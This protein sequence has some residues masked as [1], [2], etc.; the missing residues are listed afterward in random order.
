MT[1]FP[2]SPRLTKGA[3]IAV[4]PFN[5]AASIVVFQYNPEDLTRTITPSY[6]ESGG[7]NEVLRLNGAP[8]ETISVKIQIDAID[9]LES[10]N[11]T[12]KRT[13]IHPQLASLEMMVYPKTGHVIANSV[14][15]AGGF[16]EVVPPEA[17][18]TLFIWGLHRVVPVKVASLSIAEKD[19]D[20]LLNPIRAEA[21][22]SLNVLTYDDFP[23]T[24][25]GFHTFM[26]HQVVK[27]TMAILGSA[28][29]IVDVVT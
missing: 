1:T 17:P 20:A 13:G 29:S 9:Q 2:G 3:L 25:P 6:I 4:D 10:G 26:A 14:M 21:T 11:D 19:F 5:P 28:G 18:F 16:I 22:L 8:N 7:G 23:I 27:E 24:H 12:A 15:M